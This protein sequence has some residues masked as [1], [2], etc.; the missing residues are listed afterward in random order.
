MKVSLQGK[1]DNN[2]DIEIKLNW[3]LSMYRT[4]SRYSD[5]ENRTVSACVIMI[6]W[7]IGSLTITGFIFL[8]KE[9]RWKEV[10][11]WSVAPESRIHSLGLVLLILQVIDKTLPMCA[12]LE[13]MIVP[14]WFTCEMLWIKLC[15]H[16]SAIKAL[17]CWE[18]NLIL[19]PCTSW[20]YSRAKLSPS[21]FTSFA[22]LMVEPWGLWYFCPGGYP[23][24]L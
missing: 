12:L 18:V 16:S 15:C 8:Q 11:T 9:N 21:S 1:E 7:P 14:I 6:E 23:C 4:S 22:L 17:Y 19:I 2:L 13:P 3:K 10:V 20:F 5:W 24:F